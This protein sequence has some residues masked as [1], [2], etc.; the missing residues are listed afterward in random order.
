[1]RGELYDSVVK[2][3]CLHKII[4][5]IIIIIKL[6]REPHVDGPLRKILPRQI[7]VDINPY[8]LV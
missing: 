8:L 6:G 1:M 5:I 4:I 3:G 7:D 2:F